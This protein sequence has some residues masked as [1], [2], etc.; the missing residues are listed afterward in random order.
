[1]VELKRGFCHAKNGEQCRRNDAAEASAMTIGTAAA[2]AAIRMAGMI[3]GE[4]N[5]CGRDLNQISGGWC[6]V[7]NRRRI[8]M[9]RHWRVNMACVSRGGRRSKRDQQG[10]AKDR[11]DDARRDVGPQNHARFYTGLTGFENPATTSRFK[12]QGC[13]SG[14]K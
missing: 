1:M 4:W 10:K 9:N 3:G 7:G 6:C 5:L 13:A 8:G 11:Q 14:E 12:D 2:V